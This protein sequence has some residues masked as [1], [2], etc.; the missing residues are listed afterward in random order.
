MCVKKVLQENVTKCSSNLICLQAYTGVKANSRDCFKTKAWSLKSSAISVPKKLQ[1]Q[2]HCQ[3]QDHKNDDLKEGYRLITE[4]VFLVQT[5]ED[6]IQHSAAWEKINQVTL[7]EIWT[8]EQFSRDLSPINT[9]YT[10]CFKKTGTLFVFAITLSTVSQ[11]AQ[12]LAHV[13][14]RKFANCG[15]IVSP[16]NMVCV[17][18]LPC[19]ILT[20]TFFTLNSIHCCKKVEFLLWQ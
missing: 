7:S 18:T 15:C 13:H 14:Y 6:K 20:T 9:I 10:L 3:E 8:V 1:L 4:E 5:P 17:T 12:F 11:F 16:P 2:G 19:K